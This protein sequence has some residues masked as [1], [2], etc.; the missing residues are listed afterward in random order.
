MIG[1]LGD[2]EFEV[3]FEKIR[4]FS[5]MQIQR[6]AKYAEHSIHG[7]KALLEFTGFSP[8]SLSL[9]IKIDAALG[10]DPQEELDALHEILNKHEAVPFI[11]DG[12]PQGEGLWVLESLDENY[13]VINNKGTFISVETSLKLKEYIGLE[14]EEDE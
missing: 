8:A 10:V 4:T 6:G 13:E 11:L 9:K 7:C 5:D 3:S 2:V 1:N 12:E 14:D